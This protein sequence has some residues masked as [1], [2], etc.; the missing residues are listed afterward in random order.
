M[1]RAEGPHEKEKMAHAMHKLTVVVH[2]VVPRVG[3]LE[4]KTKKKCTG[5]EPQLF[6]F[7]KRMERKKQ[8]GANKRAIGASNVREMC[9]FFLP[10]GV[11]ASSS[12][13]EKIHLIKFN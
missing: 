10:F 7:E 13:H 11:A 6:F 3:P 1:L 5:L 8:T 4:A 12:W 2:E 9:L